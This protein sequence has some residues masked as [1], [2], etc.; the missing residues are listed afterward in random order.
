MGIDISK[1]SQVKMRNNT[2][3]Q[4]NEKATIGI[5]TKRKKTLQRYAFSSRDGSR[6]ANVG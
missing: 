5:E 6:F 3:M 1:F 4:E 2:I